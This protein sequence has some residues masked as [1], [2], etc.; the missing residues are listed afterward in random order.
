MKMTH[1]EAKVFSQFGRSFFGRNILRCP[2]TKNFARSSRDREDGSL[3]TCGFQ[4]ADAFMAVN[5]KASRGCYF[6]GSNAGSG[7]SR[8]GVRKQIAIPKVVTDPKKIR[9]G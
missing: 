9:H 4:G 8:G 2:G 3:E 1:P 7:F 5:C 6:T